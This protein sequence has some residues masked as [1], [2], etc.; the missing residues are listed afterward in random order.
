[1]RRRGRELRES[2][3]K[4]GDD[5]GRISRIA[6]KIPGFEPPE[7]VASMKPIHIQIYEIDSIV[8]LNLDMPGSCVWVILGSNEIVIQNQDVWFG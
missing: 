1:M 2:A 5:S 4:R 3:W 8:I 7:E 6:M